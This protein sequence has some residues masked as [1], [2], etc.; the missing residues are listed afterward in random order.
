[1][2]ICVK[3]L[4]S[5]VFLFGSI[6]AILLALNFHQQTG[7][8][9]TKIL[10]TFAYIILWLGTWMSLETMVQFYTRDKPQMKFVSGIVLMFIGLGILYAFP[11]YY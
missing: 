8:A 11:K 3:M 5:A 7:E 4:K 2:N 6:F 1:M 9:Q 10:S